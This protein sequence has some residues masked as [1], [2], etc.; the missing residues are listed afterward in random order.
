[1]ERLH[2]PHAAAKTGRVSYTLLLTVSA[3]RLAKRA[4]TDAKTLVDAAVGAY[5][6]SGNLHDGKRALFDAAA[7]LRRPAHGPGGAAA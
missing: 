3:R 1:M 4:R 5:R 2:E 6:N 7:Q